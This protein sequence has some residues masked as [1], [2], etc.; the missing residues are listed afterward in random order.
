VLD[1]ISLDQL[2][3][4]ITAADTGSFSAAARR[5]GRAQS[6][7]SQSI[8]NLEAQIGMPLFDRQG[9]YPLLTEQGRQLL[10]DARTVSGGIDAL[11]ARAKGMAA[12]L[13]PELSVVLDV[14]FP[15]QALT[16]AA[17]AFLESFPLTPLRLYVEAVGAVPQAVMDGR[18]GLGVMGSIPLTIP[19][20]AREALRSVRMMTVVAP[21]H[22]LA[23]LRG[24][25]PNSDLSK[26]VQLVLTDRSALSDG[27]EFEVRSPRTWRFA[28]LGAKHAFLR[29]GLGWGGMPLSTIEAD[30]AAG[31]LVEIEI[32]GIPPTGLQMPM[33]AIYRAD[34]PPGPA[35]RWVIDRL[36]QCD[37]RER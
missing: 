22:P 30:L 11:K 21:S 26:H 25:V 5:L 33:F 32:E 10:G 27:M 29:A 4:F 12:G 7:V 1:G 18:C 19:G 28:D 34:S 16:A 37:G 24:P 31:I 17:S 6:A 14:M 3:A 36:K 15:M 9:R 20:L 35:G 23:H 13:E 2:R 8:A